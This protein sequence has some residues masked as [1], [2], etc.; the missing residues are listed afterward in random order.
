MIWHNPVTADGEF[1]RAGRRTSS[2]GAESC[3][4]RMSWPRCR[5]AWL[6]IET[7]IG[8]AH[9]AGLEVLAWSPTPEMAVR[10]ASAGADALTVDDIP[11]VLAALAA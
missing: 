4:W 5:P 11:G 6:T 9:Q 3:G 7:V 2:P 8:L 10:L 1:T